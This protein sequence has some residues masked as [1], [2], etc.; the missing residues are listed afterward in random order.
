MA[1]MGRIWE[2]CFGVVVELG[3][4]YVVETIQTAPGASSQDYTFG[5]GY[6]IDTSSYLSDNSVTFNS[7]DVLSGVGKVMKVVTSHYVKY[8]NHF[9]SGAG[10]TYLAN[11]NGFSAVLDYVNNSTSSANAFIGEGVYFNKYTTIVTYQLPGKNALLNQRYFLL[12]NEYKLS[13]H[14]RLVAPAGI[15]SYHNGLGARVTTVS[16]GAGVM[17]VF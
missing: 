4:P 16:T 13:K 3:G 12:N 1:I 8:Y 5:V 2:S 15:N 14:L 7:A 9:L 10:A 17:F 11:T 6:K